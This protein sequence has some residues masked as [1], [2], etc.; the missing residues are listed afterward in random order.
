[1]VF[2]RPNARSTDARLSYSKSVFLKLV[3]AKGCLGFKETKI[4]NGVRPRFVCM[5]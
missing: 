2:G 1:M 3:S 5:N 4:H